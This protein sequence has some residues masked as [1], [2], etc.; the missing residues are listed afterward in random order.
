MG[1]PFSI[2]KATPAN[3]G[4]FLV[5]SYFCG[6]PKWSEQ[7][8]PDLAG[9][10]AVVTG[11]NAGLGKQTVRALLQHNAKVYM[12]CRSRVK[13]EAVIAELKELTGKEAIFLEMDLAD[14]ASVKRAAD[15][16]LS[17]EERLNI[18]YNN[19]GIMCP[20]IELVS[21]DGFDLTFGTNVVGHFY[22]TKLLLPALRAAAVADASTGGRVV[23]LTSNA[24]YIAVPRYDTF[25]DG[26]AR[27]KKLTPGDAYFQSKWANAVFAMELARRYGEEGIVSSAVNPGNLKTELAQSTRGLLSLSTSTLMIWPVEWGVLGQL[28]AGTSPEGAQLNGKYVAPWAKHGKARADVYDSKTGG[29]LWAWLEGQMPAEAL[30]DEVVSTS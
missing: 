26:P 12:A 11:G 20:P 25:K 18:L 14:L 23:N 1:I 27:K 6:R 30:K 2:R 8:I 9:Q 13:A 22:L 24:H 16:F 15:E 4:P 17:K 28:W 3:V 5:Q 10:V 19:G 21:K 29:E 7:E